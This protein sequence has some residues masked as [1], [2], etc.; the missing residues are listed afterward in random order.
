MLSPIQRLKE[1]YLAQ[2]TLKAKTRQLNGVL[3]NTVTLDC[4]VW[5]PIVP[6]ESFSATNVQL[7]AKRR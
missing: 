4:P 3:S 2:R 1:I 5:L 6:N 7:N